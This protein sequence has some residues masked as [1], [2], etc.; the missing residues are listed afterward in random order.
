MGGD[1]MLTARVALVIGA[2]FFIVTAVA[3]AVRAAC[4]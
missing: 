4:W 1:R 3:L 2:V